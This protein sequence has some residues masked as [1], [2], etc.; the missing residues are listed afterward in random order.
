[1]TAATGLGICLG[2]VEVAIPAAL[3]TQSSPGLGGLVLSG[4]TITSVLFALFYG[5]R[6]WPAEVSNRVP[7]LLA[8]FAA[9][10]AASAIP[11]APLGACALILI[12]GTLIAV[13]PTTYSLAL[14]H[15]VPNTQVAE[16][17]SWILTSMTVGAAVGQLVSG[18]IVEIFNARTALACVGL[19]GLGAAI[20]VALQRAGLTEQHR[21]VRTGTF[22]TTQDS[23]SSQ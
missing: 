8:A 16:G 14:Q 12:A 10:I 19:I 6:P 15:V 9:L 2:G 3:R 18:Q 23:T 21:Q 7:A 22:E 17:F 4:W 1:M 13:Q 11:R 5:T 20:A